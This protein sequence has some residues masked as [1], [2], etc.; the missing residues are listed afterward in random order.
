MIRYLV[1]SENVTLREYDLFSLEYF[2]ANRQYGI[3]DIKIIWE[4]TV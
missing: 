2:I 3:L 4:L 1:I